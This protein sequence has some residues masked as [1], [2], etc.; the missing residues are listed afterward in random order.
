MSTDRDRPR[1][2]RQLVADVLGASP[3][4]ERRL[5]LDLL[6]VELLAVKVYALAGA[7]AHVSTGGRALARRVEDQELSHAA[8]LARLSGLVAPRRPAL[9]TTAAEAALA[10]HGITVTFSSLTSERQWFT[11]LERLESALEGAYFKALG[12]LSDPAHA[13]LAARILASEAQ[14][15]TLLFSFRNPQNVDLAVA[16]GLVEG[17]TAQNG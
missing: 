13:T 15:S 6:D 10:G 5:L 7:S 12:R 17:S 1:S 9:S 2:R 4:Q 11:L 16:V 14:H 8:A 3:A